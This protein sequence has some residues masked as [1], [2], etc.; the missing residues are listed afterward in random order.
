MLSCTIDELSFPELVASVHVTKSTEMSLTRDVAET[1]FR[2]IDEDQSGWIDL[3]ELRE[4]LD[5]TLC[6]DT[7]GDPSF[8]SGGLGCGAAAA[9][10]SSNAGASPF[11]DGAAAS[12]FS[13]NAGA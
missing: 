1:L 8:P 10:F 4:A 11:S 13:S 12:P 3:L 2:A 9:P 6:G 7:E 5:R